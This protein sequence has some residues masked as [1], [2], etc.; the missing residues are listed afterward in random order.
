MTK[1]FILGGIVMIL[2]GIMLGVGGFFFY[3]TNKEKIAQSEQV[4]ATIDEIETIHKRN[5]KGKTKTEHKVYIDFEYDDKEYEH[6]KLGYYDSSM[7][8]GNDID[9]YV[10]EPSNGDIEVLTEGAGTVIIIV[11][12]LFAAVLVGVGIGMIALNAGGNKKERY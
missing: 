1:K 2:I 5:S 3:K 6:Y 12:T 8:E 11:F 9:V 7:H 4:T 10:Y